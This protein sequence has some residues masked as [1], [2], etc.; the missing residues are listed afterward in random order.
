MIPAGSALN[1]TVVT[2]YLIFTLQPFT[3][4]LRSAKIA[5]VVKT[6]VTK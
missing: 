5:G 2:A 6:P 4:S 3:K 1:W